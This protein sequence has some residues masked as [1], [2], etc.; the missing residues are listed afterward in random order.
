MAQIGAS[1]QNA[2]GIAMPGMLADTSL[3]N[4]DGACACDGNIAIGVAVGV[5]EAQPVDGHK[6]V[7]LASANVAPYGVVLR[8]HA[9]SPKGVYEDG[10]AV[11]VVTHGRIWMVCDDA[12]APGAFGSQ[13]KLAATG[14][15]AKAGTIATGWTY[16]GGFTK[17][18]DVNIVEVQLI[19]NAPV[20]AAAGA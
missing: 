18:R 1:Y 16:A 10:C 17:W 19:Q 15:A 14:H 6:V 4:V 9:H 5:T 2:M 8:S 11:N 13:V 12:T 3:Y 7:A 20:P